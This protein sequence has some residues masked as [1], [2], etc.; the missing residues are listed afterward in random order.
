MMAIEIKTAIQVFNDLI[1]CSMCENPLE[2]CG[3]CKHKTFCDIG[4]EEPS[5]LFIESCHLAIAAFE[6]QVYLQNQVNT[7]YLVGYEDGRQGNKCDYGKL[8]G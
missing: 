1:Y 4:G 5:S 2:D 7:A 6:Q 3:K 8:K